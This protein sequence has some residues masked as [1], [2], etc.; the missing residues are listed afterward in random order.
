LIQSFSFYDAWQKIS[1]KSSR[2][3]ACRVRG[4]GRRGSL[5]DNNEAQ[6]SNK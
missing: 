4:G 6:V 2:K 1:T 5:S 3:L